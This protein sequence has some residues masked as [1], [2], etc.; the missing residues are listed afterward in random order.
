MLEEGERITEETGL[1]DGY[2]NKVKQLSEEKVSLDEIRNK[3]AVNVKK[4]DPDG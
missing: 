4:S 3:S 1:D 2:S